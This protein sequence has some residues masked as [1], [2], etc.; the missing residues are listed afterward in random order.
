MSRYGFFYQHDLFQTVYRFRCVI[1]I[2]SE[3]TL[4]YLCLL[5]GRNL[6][7]RFNPE[8]G[9]GS[10]VI[11]RIQPSLP[12]GNITISIR[13]LFQ[14]GLH[15]VFANLIDDFSKVPDTGGPKRIRKINV[16]VP[17]FIPEYLPAPCAHGVGRIKNAVLQRKERRNDFKS[18]AGRPSGR[19]KFFIVY[20]TGSF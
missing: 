20:H 8:S 15:P 19:C 6:E 9:Q 16:P 5:P 17:I 12:I 2:V 13:N 3:D 14:S 1:C 18:R 10:I 4:H 11:V 7:R